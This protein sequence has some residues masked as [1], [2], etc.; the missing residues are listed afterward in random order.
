MRAAAKRRSSCVER[1]LYGGRREEG[2]SLLNGPDWIENDVTLLGPYGG[3]ESKNFRGA[4]GSGQVRNMPG[5]LHLMGA[6][7]A[8]AHSSS[9]DRASYQNF[10]Q[11]EASCRRCKHSSPLRLDIL[12][13][14]VESE[15]TVGRVREN[16]VAV[17]TRLEYLRIPGRRTPGSA[18]RFVGPTPTRRGR[19]SLSANFAFEHRRQPNGLPSPHIA[20]LSPHRAELINAKRH[21]LRKGVARGQKENQKREANKRVARKKL[22]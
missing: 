15:G 9:L 18:K 8:S 7:L 13:S 19:L 2:V 6:E 1:R 5:F 14:A 20:A 22:K 17:T 11:S 21:R 3:L 10:A 4:S 12:S 16:V